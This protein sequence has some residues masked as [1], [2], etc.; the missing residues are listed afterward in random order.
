MDI[1]VAI[2]FLPITAYDPQNYTAYSILSQK[3][4][5]D[6]VVWKT[7]GPNHLLIRLTLV[8]QRQIDFTSFSLTLSNCIIRQ[9]RDWDQ[10]YFFRGNNIGIIKTLIGREIIEEV[11]TLI[12]TESLIAGKRQEHEQF[13]M[14]CNRRN[15]TLSNNFGENIQKSMLL[16]F[17]SVVS[18]PI[19]MRSDYC[20]TLDEARRM[21]YW[22]FTNEIPVTIIWTDRK[23]QSPRWKHL[24]E[25]WRR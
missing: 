10:R 24:T 25:T 21:T 18:R 7:W 11:K 12:Y 17:R 19:L 14:N 3:Y 5:F 4:I 15:V 2:F 23:K 16:R 9:F 8:G 6:S 22:A 20:W 13:S 1:H